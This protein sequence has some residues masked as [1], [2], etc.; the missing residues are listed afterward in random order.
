MNHDCTRAA[1]C[2]LAVCL[3]AGAAGCSPKAVE[4]AVQEKSIYVETVTPETGDLSLSTEFIGTVEPDELVSVF[5]K[6]AGTVLAVYKNVGEEVKKGDLLF[7]IDPS[8]IQLSVNIAQAQLMSAQAQMDQAL[9]SSFDMQMIQ[10]E[11]QLKQAQNAYSTARQSLRDYND[12]V[13]DSMDDLEDTINELKPA[14]PALE[15]AYDEASKKA[16]EAHSDYITLNKDPNADAK[17]V[18]DAYD[19]WQNA[20][21][22]KNSAYAKL[23]ETESTLSMLRANYNDLDDD[24]SSTHSQLRSAVRN[25]QTAYESAEQIYELTKDA[26]HNDA[27]K[28]AKASLGQATAAFEAQAK[29][30]EYTRVTSPINGVIEQKNVSE[31]GIASQSSPAFTVSNKSTLMVTFYVP[32]DAVEQMVP[33]DKVTIENGRNTYD[34]TIAEIGTMVDPATGL[35]KVKASADQDDGTLLTGLSVKVTADTA[36]A[37]GSL[38]IPQSVVYYEDGAA[39]VYLLENGHAVKT[40][41]ETGISNEQSVEVISGLTGASQVIANWHPNLTDGAAVI[42]AAEAAGDAASAEAAVSSEEESPDESAPADKTDRS[43]AGASDAASDG[44][45]ED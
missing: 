36:K 9:G 7:E 18:E 16:T 40:F 37:H 4:T 27:I 44:A 38:L 22:E 12:G 6:V 31:Q 24:D 30:L 28:V 13:G 19:A 42:P 21:K 39:Y 32:A 14:I 43:D 10:L 2:M 33:G 11:S 45:Q 8:D 23:Q 34:G 17:A 15:A 26:V 29:Q 5:P 41:I 35:F 1:A 25:A 20:L 3:M